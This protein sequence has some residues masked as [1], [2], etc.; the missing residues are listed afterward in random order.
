MCWGSVVVLI[1]MHGVPGDISLIAR[2]FGHSE[3]KSAQPGD[4]VSRAH[5]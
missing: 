4:L 3:R 5:Q 1:D 2:L